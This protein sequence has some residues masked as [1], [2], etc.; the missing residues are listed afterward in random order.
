MLITCS[1][2]WYQLYEGST[3]EFQPNQI[4]AVELRDARMYVNMCKSVCFYIRLLR[5]IVHRNSM[6]DVGFKK[7]L[8]KILR[9][10]SVCRTSTHVH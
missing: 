5:R 4:K 8:T 7:Y 6:T 3:Y 9:C 2:S 1:F 10:S